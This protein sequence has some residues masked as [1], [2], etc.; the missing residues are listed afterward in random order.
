MSDGG[1]P[2]YP[3]GV[4]PRDQFAQNAPAPQTQALTPPDAPYAAAGA[5]YNPGPPSSERTNTLSIVALVGGFFIGLLG[6]IAGAI[7]LRQIKK[8]GER[9]RGLAIGGIVVGSLNM[10]AGIIAIVLVVVAFMA[11]ASAAESLSEQPQSSVS[12]P[13]TAPEEDGAT[14]TDGATPSAELCAAVTELTSI[15]QSELTGG[16][17]E[18]MA[19]LEA[20]AA[21][22]GDNQETYGQ[23]VDL[24]GDPMSVPAEDQQQLYTD[25]ATALQEDAMAC[26]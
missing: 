10:L 26:M 5:G 18:A 19:A 17:A 13:A 20:L 2:G 22:P 3:G 9:G 7:A 11:A 16:S 21:A 1:Q 23:I 8:S 14:G 4:P 12:E 6:V 25:F 15:D 24:M